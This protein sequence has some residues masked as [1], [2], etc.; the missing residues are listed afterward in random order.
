MNNEKKD[1]SD[2]RVRDREQFLSIIKQ[3]EEKSNAYRN[4][5]LFIPKTCG[6]CS[7]YSQNDLC[8]F[9]IAMYEEKRLH[10]IIILIFASLIF[11]YLIYKA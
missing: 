5:I 11:I 4:Y 8:Y 9:C 1:W 6:E 7:K 10:A 3:L 2:P